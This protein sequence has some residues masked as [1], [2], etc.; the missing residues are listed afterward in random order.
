MSRKYAVIKPIF[1]NGSTAK[2]LRG[3]H[4]AQAL[5]FYVMTCK[6]SRM[7]G[8]YSLAL[9]T[10]CR[11]LGMGELQAKTTLQRLELHGFLKYDFVDE[12]VWVPNLSLHQVGESLKAADTK[13]VAILNNLE[14]FKNHSYYNEFIDKYGGPYGVSHGVYDT[15]LFPDT[16]S[17]NSESENKS[18]KSAKKSKPPT[19]PG[20]SVVVSYFH[21]AF[22][23]CKGVKPVINSREGKAAN[24]LLASF[25]PEEIKAMITRAFQ[26]DW[27]VKNNPTLAHIANNANKYIGKKSSKEPTRGWGEFE[28][29]GD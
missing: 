2:S 23:E 29:E 11:E 20:Y 26:D 28:D 14:D 5:V 22:L 8:L 4:A 18:K 1:W 21:G 24:E 25:A 15:T 17:L 16:C 3:D 7:T 19:H 27:F 10:I 13:R 6:D 12:I 9:S